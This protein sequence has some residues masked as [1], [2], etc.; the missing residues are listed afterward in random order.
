MDAREKILLDY[1]RSWIEKDIAVLYQAFD[2]HAT[3]VESWG[4]AYRGLAQIARWFQDWNERNSVLRWDIK[5]FFHQ[6]DTCVCEWHFECD[7]DGTAHAFDGVSIV[8][9]NGDN[10]IVGLQEFQSKIPN[11]CPYE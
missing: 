8:S 11:Y 10:K 4:P 3:Y 9:F 7:C 2:S 1:F 6:A 5:R